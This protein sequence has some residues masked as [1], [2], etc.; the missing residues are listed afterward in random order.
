MAS[1]TAHDRG[2]SQPVDE[3]CGE[4]DW[5]IQGARLDLDDRTPYE[6]LTGHT[7]DTSELTDFDFYQ[8][9]IYYDPN[10]HNEE[11]GMARRKLGRWLGPSKSVG[12]ALCYYILKENGQV[13]GETY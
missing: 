6:V 3:S 2:A 4:R 5:A 8:F 1:H 12:Q 10:D 13:N 11:S 7:P 9:V